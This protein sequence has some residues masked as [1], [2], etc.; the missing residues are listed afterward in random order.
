MR[1]EEELA[2]AVRKMVGWHYDEIFLA[3]KDTW[4]KSPDQDCIGVCG[5]YKTMLQ[6]ATGLLSEDV[7]DGA[8]MFE[9]VSEVSA[10][11]GWQTAAAS[12]QPPR[13]GP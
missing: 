3:V 4:K 9:N 2:D 10:E 6:K 11:R 5:L 13:P 12:A 1:M 8:D 7:F